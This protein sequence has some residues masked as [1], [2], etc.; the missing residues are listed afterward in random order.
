MLI[1]NLVATGSAIVSGFSTITGDLTVLGSINGSIGNAVSASY[2]STS[3]FADDFTVAGTLTAQKI[4]V[5]TVT[6]SVVYS[7][8][9]NVF[10]NNISNTQ[11]MTGSVSITGSLTVNGVNS[12]V[13]SGTTNQLSKFTG[14]STIGNSTFYD[15]GTL[16]AVGNRITTNSFVGLVRNFNILGTDA[17][18]RVARYTDS[19]TT[20]SPSV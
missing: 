2:A 9:S 10:G 13:G 20:E 11:V 5:Q 16:T 6:S 17:V 14:T 15:N 8:G 4:V 3:S 18:L 12:V 7:S 19:F 1:H